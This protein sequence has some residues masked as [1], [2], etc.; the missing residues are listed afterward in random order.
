[1]MSRPSNSSTV[2]NSNAEAVTIEA[3][4]IFV[5]KRLVKKPKFRKILYMDD[6]TSHIKLDI[7]LALNKRVRELKGFQ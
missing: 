2:N 6:D 7:V 4:Q 5:L 3:N 1:M